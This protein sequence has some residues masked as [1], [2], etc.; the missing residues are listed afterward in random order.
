L[1]LTHLVKIQA[2]AVM[3][4]LPSKICRVFQFSLWGVPSRV[5]A[6]R[7]CESDTRAAPT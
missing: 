5:A 6:C 3:V 7:G 2:V 4:W 1:F